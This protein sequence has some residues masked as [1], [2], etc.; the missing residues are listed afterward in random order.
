M[1]ESPTPDGVRLLRLADEPELVQ[2]MYELAVST[3]GDRTDR[4]GGLVPTGTDWRMY[5][6]SSPFVRLEMTAVATADDK[7]VGDSVIQD[8]P[9]HG[10]LLHR[11]LAVA[12]GWRERGLARTLVTETIRDAAARACR[13]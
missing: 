6:L 12:P 4:L 13:G 7:V 1:V 5:E 11:T 9:G 2:A 3:A 10:V 8:F